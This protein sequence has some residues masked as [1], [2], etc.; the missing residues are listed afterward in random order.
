MVAPFFAGL[1]QMAE[2]RI[3]NADVGGSMPPSGTN[4]EGQS[5]RGGRRPEPGWCATRMGIVTSAFRHFGTG[6]DDV[7]AAGGVDLVPEGTISTRI[8][9]RVHTRT[10]P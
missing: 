5:A 3:R 6:A 4:M 9:T 1:A 2:R 7:D 8:C 10:P